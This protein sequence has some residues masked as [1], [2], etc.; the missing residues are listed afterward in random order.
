MV[1][2]QVAVA[3]AV[4]VDTYT[5]SVALVRKFVHNRKIMLLK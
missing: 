5:E 3:V 1:A 4:R 2:E